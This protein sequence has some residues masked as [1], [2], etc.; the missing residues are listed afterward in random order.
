VPALSSARSNS[1]LRPVIFRNRLVA[2]LVLALRRD[3]KLPPPERSAPN[4]PEA[5]GVKLQPVDDLVDHLAL[6]AHG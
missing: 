4:A 5:L 2:D 1:N 6:G 3:V